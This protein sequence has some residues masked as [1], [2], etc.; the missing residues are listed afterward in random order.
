MPAKKLSEARS[1]RLKRSNDFLCARMPR[2]AL[3]WRG[4]PA[5][6]PSCIAPSSSTRH[7]VRDDDGR[8]DHAAGTRMQPDTRHADRFLS[9][10]D[11]RATHLACRQHYRA[12]HPRDQIDVIAEEGAVGEFQPGEERVVRRMPAMG[13]HMQD[14]D[15]GCQRRHSRRRRPFAIENDRVAPRAGTEGSLLGTSLDSGTNG[16]ACRRRLR[17]VHRVPQAR[18]SGRRHGDRERPSAQ[19]AASP[20]GSR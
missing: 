14:I 2:P 17:I 9:P 13:R 4:L 20:R 18:P 8:R 15:A 16:E 7:V 19:A 10:S 5:A 11:G 6:R 1:V 12:R 3:R